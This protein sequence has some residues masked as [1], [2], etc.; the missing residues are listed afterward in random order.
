MTESE[1]GARIERKLT[2]ILA[3]DIA[4]YS[5]L[6]ERD[7][8]GTLERLRDC[9]R[10]LG[11]LVLRHRGRIANTAGD[12]VLAEF[13]SVVEAVR[14]AVE[15]QQ[16]LGARNAGLPDDRRMAF[17]IGLNLGDVMVEG[18][19]LFGE[20]VNVAARL[21]TLAEPGGIL[22]SGTVHDLVRGKLDI[23]YDWLG[24]RQVKNIDREIPVWRI[25][26]GGEGAPDATIEPH[27]PGAP[28]VRPRRSARPA[29]PRRAPTAGTWREGRPLRLGLFALALLVAAPIA[30]LGWLVWPAI[31]IGFA[32]LSVAAVRV[33]LPKRRHPRRAARPP[34]AAPGRHQSRERRPGLVGGLSGV[35]RSSPWP[36]PSTPAFRS[37]SWRSAG[38]WRGVVETR[39]RRPDR[40]ALWPVTM[41][42]PPTRPDGRGYGARAG[43]PSSVPLPLVGRLCG[44][45]DRRPVL[46][47]H[48]PRRRPLCSYL[49]D[50]PGRGDGAPRTLAAPLARRCCRS[51]S[52][53][54]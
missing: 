29:R 21:Q 44:G 32:S 19:D 4:G 39:G 30:G 40:R 14:C 10:L 18:G 47:A 8:A 51:P 36:S 3:A 6:M 38:I 22:I 43:S 48:H 11:G 28:A 41:P 23:G 42:Q 54:S 12:G 1:A 27:A 9:R 45:Q 35:S 46:P 20:G 26:L 49:A 52:R 15:I 33:G 25:R 37:A 34:R 13:P 50:L 16:E 24:D 5:R 2:T 17:R 7:E 53:A 31:G